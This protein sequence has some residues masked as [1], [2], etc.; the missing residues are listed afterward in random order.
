MIDI[1][2][3]YVT[4]KDK[5]SGESLGTYLLSVEFYAFLDMPQHVIAEGTAY[6]VYLRFKRVYKPYSIQLNKF[7]HDRY[8]GTDIPKNYSS[9]VVLDDP[10]RN[11]KRE[12]LIWM[13]HPMYYDGDTFYQADFLK[14]QQRGTILQ[15]VHNPGWTL[16]YIACG[17][18]VIGMLLHFG[19]T[20]INFVVKHAT[21]VLTNRPVN[22]RRNLSVA[23]ANIFSWNIVGVPVF[24]VGVAFLYLI[25]AMMP[26]STATGAFD[27]NSAGNIQIVDGGR[28]KPLDSFAR[29][30]LMIISGK[31][32]FYDDNKEEH[33]AVEWL[34]DVMTSTITKNGKAESYKGLPHRERSGVKAYSGYRRSSGSY[35]Y[36]IDEIASKE[37]N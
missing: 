4:F 14:G 12:V 19:L 33:S 30:K 2:A 24:V 16:P 31:Q 9:L 32:S 36:S 25:V 1:P 10:A 5:K 29:V 37:K 8:D 21:A 27:Y 18:V 17:M 23:K 26:P 7:S 20:L 3:A 22:G 15:V 13:N 28:N 35:R 11:E 6:D 34:L